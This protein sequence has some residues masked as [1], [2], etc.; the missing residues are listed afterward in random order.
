MAA[1]MSKLT[2]IQKRDWSIDADNFLYFRCPKCNKSFQRAIFGG[3]VNRYGIIRLSFY[4]TPSTGGCEHMCRL[5]LYG[6]TGTWQE[7]DAS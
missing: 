4:C 2:I 6:W 5:R 1:T 7:R 3:D